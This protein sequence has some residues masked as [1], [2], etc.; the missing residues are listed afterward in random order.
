MVSYV[1]YLWVISE[2]NQWASPYVFWELTI[3]FFQELKN[4]NNGLRSKLRLFLGRSRLR[5]DPDAYAN[6]V[7]SIFLRFKTMVN[8]FLGGGLCCVS[9]LQ[10]YDAGFQLCLDV[11]Y[12]VYWLHVVISFQGCYYNYSWAEWAWVSAK[13]ICLS[14]LVSFLLT[15]F[16]WTM[17]WQC[18][19]HGF[20]L[21]FGL[22]F[23][24]Y[25]SLYTVNLIF[26]CCWF[27]VAGMLIL[28]GS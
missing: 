24:V 15:T 1:L 12:F 5:L 25:L 21:G 3:P 18:Y 28:Q 27:T 9:Y 23:T 19:I 14:C 2:P 22:L 17:N 26:F 10:K 13:S 6:Q 20:I 4:F 16:V 8:F 11:N 7:F